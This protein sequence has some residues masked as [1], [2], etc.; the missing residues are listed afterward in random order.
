MII[1]PACNKPIEPGQDIGTRGTSFIH[2]ACAEAGDEVELLT[3]EMGL[4]VSIPV[5]AHSSIAEKE[6]QVRAAMVRLFEKLIR[7][8]V[9]TLTIQTDPETGE[10]KIIL[11]E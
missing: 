7:D 10:Q 8:S 3:L 1:C 6:E 9:A 5:L 11:G 4:T 2:V